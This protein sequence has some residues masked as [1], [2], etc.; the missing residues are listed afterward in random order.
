M[1]AAMGVSKETDDPII[2]AGDLVACLPGHYRCL[3]I[4]CD[5]PY[6]D[7]IH[8]QGVVNGRSMKFWVHECECTLIRKGIK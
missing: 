8:V 2:E 3:V 5:G 7:F 1:C 4:S 6:R